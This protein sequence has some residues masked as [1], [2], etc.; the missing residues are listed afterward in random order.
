[1]IGTLRYLCN[2]RSHL[3]YSVGIVRK[4][5][6]KT[7]ASYFALVR[8]FWDTLKVRLDAEFKILQWR[9][10]EVVNCSIT[11]TQTGV[12]IKMIENPV[13]DIYIYEETPFSWCYKKKSVVVL[14]SCETGYIVVSMFT[15]KTICL[16]KELYNKENEVVKLVIGNVSAINLANN[17]IAH[18][19]SKHILWVKE[20]W[21]W[22]IAT[23]VSEVGGFEWR[24]D[25]LVLKVF[26]T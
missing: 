6:G 22:G 15:C 13:L 11:L 16:M 5:M 19:R 10:V 8:D 18:G 1:M 24:I 20:N 25:S 23:T 21:I 14:S 12:D 7:F 17:Q 4:F 3:A 26:L 9:E 2:T